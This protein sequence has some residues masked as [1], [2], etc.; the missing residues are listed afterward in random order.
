MVPGDLMAK[1]PKIVVL[2]PKDSNIFGIITRVVRALRE[3]KVQDDDIE[4]FR[5]E[6]MMSSPSLI[7][8]VVRR[9]VQYTPKSS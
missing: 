5:L 2:E 1:Y 3:A 6:M 4:A 7:P 8:Q 9:W